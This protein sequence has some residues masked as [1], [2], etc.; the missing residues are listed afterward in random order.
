MPWKEVSVEEMAKRLGVDVSEVREKQ[1]LIAQ[2][3]KVR[4]ASGL[5]QH[6]LAK[7]LG[8]TQGRIAQIESGI[9]TSHVTF[10][11]LLKTLCA[12]GYE[13]RILARRAA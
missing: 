5:S 9:G 13:Y 12:L 8:V 7:M 2:I 3:V 11:V 10:D 1:R 4:K 6:A